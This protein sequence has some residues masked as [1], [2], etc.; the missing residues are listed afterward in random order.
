[1][2]SVVLPGSNL[3]VSR[4]GFGCCPMGGHGWG[5]VSVDDFKKAVELALDQG[6]NFFDTADIYGLGES[7]RLLGKFL[8]S[9][10]PEAVI[11]SK[12]G[13]RR[14]NN[15]KAFYDNSPAW[16]EQALEASL[17]RLGVDAI[18]LYQVHYL[19]QKTPLSD[20]LNTLEK[21][22]K[23]GKV[24][25]FGLS[26]VILKDIHQQSLPKELVSF[27]SEYSLANRMHEDE[28]RKIQ[29]IKKLGFLSWGSLGQGILSGK[30]HSQTTFDKNDRRSR[31]EYINFHGERYQKN[32]DM[33]D[34]I[35]NQFN[36]KDK[37][38]SQIAIRWILD[39]FENSVVL[40]GVKR[41]EQI[42][43]NIK[44]FGWRL[45]REE[46]KFLDTISH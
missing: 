45:T 19:D 23:E 9:R 2:E 25:Y 17:K 15:G 26:N 41:E 6:I 38:L 42:R 39:R 8:K 30:Y 20:V 18:D 16:I 12:F 33:L 35:K 10:R 14:D 28:I 27:Q 44:A 37:S 13:V 4:L 40:V 11:A 29:Q 31:P 46:I 7:E 43:E 3:K 21:K 5:A 34:K 24:R 36:L 32:L 1:M 22:R